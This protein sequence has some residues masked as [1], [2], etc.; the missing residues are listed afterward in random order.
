MTR[1]FFLSRTPVV[2]RAI[3]FAGQ[4]GCYVLVMAANT[5]HSAEQVTAGAGKKADAVTLKTVKITASTEKNVVDGYVAKR[6]TTASKTDT[7]LIETPQSISVITADRIEAISATTLTDAVR[8]TPGVSIHSDGFDTRGDWLIFRGFDAFEQGFF[9]DGLQLRN[10]NS[11]ITWQLEPYGAER[12]EVLRGPSSVLYGQNI[13]GGTVNAVSKLPTKESRGEIRLEAGN[14]SRREIAGDISGPIDADGEFLYRLTTLTL[15]SDTQVD[16]VPYDRDFIAPA[17]TWQPSAD[18][19]LTLLGHYLK[20]RTGSSRGSL[21]VSGTLLSNPNGRISTSTFLGEPDFNHFDQDQW[22]IGYLFEHRFNDTWTVRQNTRYGKIEVDYQEVYAGDDFITVNEDDANDPANFRII[23]REVFGAREDGK[24]LAIDNQAQA[25]LQTGDWEH[26]VL[27]GLDYQRARYTQYLF[28]S[29][30]GVSEIDVYAPT[31]GASVTIPDPYTDADLE[32]D[33]SGLY[34]QD[35]AKLGEHWVVTVGSRY[36]RFR[37]V[38]DDKL[39]PSRTSQSEGD[40]TGRAGVVYLA[41]QGWAPYV[42]YSESFSPVVT[43]VDPDTGK[44]FE[45]ETGRQYEAGL[46][47]QPPARNQ[48]YSLAVY[49]LRRRNYVT[50]DEDFN[51]RAIGEIKVNGVEF[52]ALAE[53]MPR[54]NLTFAYTWTPKA[55]VTKS[56]DPAEIGKQSNAVPEQQASLW[57]D[58]QLKSGFKLGAGAR[59]VG[60][61]DGRYESAPKTVPSYTVFDAMVGYDIEHWNFSVNA[62]NLGDKIYLSRNC[63]DTVCNYGEQR[64]VIGTVKYLW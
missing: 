42:S 41:P 44:R 13:P 35:Q 39:T 29:D 28:Y 51:P 7:P 25:I 34:L 36:D 43:D 62:R 31:Y 59:Y 52:E 4:L 26:T 54:L 38:V 63:V 1:R 23:G 5:T 18:T 8:Y 45:P 15:D 10:N 20:V 2:Q 64:Q 9:L 30:E 61:T 48:S 56:A 53:I 11:F 37:N 3:K 55:D 27:V 22:A 57:T 14:Y 60:S 47:Y 19:S 50:Y 33:Q 12:V 46:R 58:Y 49:D 40:F 32:L 6:S 24:L 21:P 16:H 17:L